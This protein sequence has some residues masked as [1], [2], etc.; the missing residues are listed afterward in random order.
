MLDSIGLDLD[1]QDKVCRALWETIYDKID[2][3]LRIHVPYFGK[4]GGDQIHN[5]K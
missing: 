5:I 3:N 2:S 1:G 4:K